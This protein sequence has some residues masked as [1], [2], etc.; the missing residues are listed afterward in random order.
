MRISLRMTAFRVALAGT[1]FLLGFSTKT[2]AAVPPEKIFPDTA[3]FFLKANDLSALR[4]AFLQSQYG[5]LLAD[6]AFKP[7]KDDM[8]ARMEERSAD[9]KAIIGLGYEELLEIPQGALAI[10][11]VPKD[12]PD[13]PAA[14]IL[15]VDAGKNEAKLT[16]VLTKAAQNG[17]AAG[18]KTTK[19]EFKGLT[20]NV[21]TPPK[22]KEP[23][24]GARPP[25]SIT[26]AKQGTVFFIG[27][28][29]DAVKDLI[30]KG[31]ERADS[32]ATSRRYIESEKKLGSDNQV[33]WYSDLS[34]FFKL[35]KKSGAKGQNAANI[36]QFEAMIPVFG[37]NGLKTASGSFNLNS[38]SFDTVTRTFVVMP[39]PL[40]GL[41]KLMALPKATLKPEPW[42][43]ATVASYQSFS[44]D[45]DASF[46]AL[47][48]LANMFQPGVINIL[49]QQ[50]VG[51]NGGEPLNFKK[52]IFDP[53]G[54]RISILTDYKK[55]ISEDSQRV[56]VSFALEDSKTFEATLQKLIS[57]AG[58]A[59]KKRSFQG[60]TIYEFDAPEVPNGP[61][62][63]NVKLQGTISVALA[64]QF[65]M[66]S[67]DP[68]LLELV[69]RGGNPPLAEDAGFLAVMKEIPEKVSSISYVRPDESARV[70]Y[71]MF[72]SGQFEK[73]LQ[74]ANVAGGPDVSKVGDLFDRKR[75]PSFSVMAKYL[76]SGGGFAVLEDD[77]VSITNFTLRKANP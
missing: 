60:V 4:E 34:N 68:T 36:D 44:L 33:F 23:K 1:L 18:T 25:V 48:D 75:L 65:L 61:A 69:I 57:L 3:A 32:V 15:T 45:L 26:W 5:Q 28:D 8:K 24:E 13:V 70:S 30:G 17:E 16:E 71:D 66:L 29:T 27:T 2:Q 31:D 55:P 51:A 56:L 67:T 20:L 22:P 49:E 9:L 53:L 72:K 11:V 54:K 14:I 38:G 6:P 7:F 50:L 63:G 41:L 73:A 21:I 42:V 59:P 64:Q 46:A 76:S 40:K 10:A 19:E 43:P 12:D 39:A 37:L 52:D 35:V 58:N 47:N 77:G 62:G 74:G